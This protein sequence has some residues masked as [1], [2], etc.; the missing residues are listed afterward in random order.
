VGFE[1]AVQEV[2]YSTLSA[3]EALTSTV[4]G[5]FDAVPQLS[6]VG[7]QGSATKIPLCDY[8]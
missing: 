7:R 6:R 8:R 5:I 2:I 3:N 4:E 1:T